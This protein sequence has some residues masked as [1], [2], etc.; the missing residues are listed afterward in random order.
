MMCR[1][2]LPRCFYR[3][4]LKW[5]WGNI[6]RRTLYQSR[7]QNTKRGGHTHAARASHGLHQRRRAARWDLRS[8]FR[9]A[10]RAPALRRRHRLVAQRQGAD[11]ARLRSRAGRSRLHSV[12]LRLFRLGR[13]RRLPAPLG[14]AHPEGARHRRR[15]RLCL[16]ALLRGPQCRLP[17]GVRERPV[18]AARRGRLGANREPRLGRRLVPRRRGAPRART[19]RACQRRARRIPPHRQALHGARLRRRRR[20]G[21]NVVRDGLLLEP[22]ARGR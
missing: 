4:R 9:F 15:G 1:R 5:W 21:R 14:T 19:A 18:R 20:A 16:V 17:G 2:R 13:E 7:H 3:A 22:R 10:Q 11:G 6:K 8:Q 12:H